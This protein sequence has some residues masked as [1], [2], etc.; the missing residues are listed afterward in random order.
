M[1]PVRGQRTWTAPRAPG[2]PCRRRSSGRRAAPGA[3][4]PPPSSSATVTPITSRSRGVRAAVPDAPW[5]VRSAP[6]A[7]WR[8]GG[9]RRGAA[10]DRRRAAGPD[11]PRHGIVPARPL[12]R[13]GRRDRGDDGAPRDRA[14]D[15][16]PLPAG[17]R[18]RA[19]DRRRRPRALRPSAPSSSSSPCGAPSSS[20]R[21]TSWR[22]PGGARRRGSPASSARGWPRRSSR[23]GSPTT[24]PP[25]STGVRGRAGPARRR[26][27]ALGRPL[28]ASSC[29]SST[30]AS[31][32][33]SARPTAPTCR[34]APRVLT[35]LGVEG[36]LARGRN[37]GHWRDLA[38]RSGRRW[39]PGWA[40]YPSRRGRPT[41]AGPSWSAVGCGPSG[42]APRPTSSGG[43][44]A[45]VGIVKQALADIGAE[46]VTLDGAETGWLLPD[47]LDEVTHDDRWV[48]LLPVLDP[49]VMG[50]KARDFY[51]DAAHVPPCSSTATATPAP[52]PGGTGGSS[53]AGCRTQP[54]SS[55][56]GTSRRCPRRARRALAVEAD[57]LTA[58]LDGVRVGTV[59]P[60]AAMKG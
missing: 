31:T 59:Y 17:P 33:P 37:G 36:L 41:R 54:G 19:D 53:A 43:S 4:A 47:D 49:T 22:R 16:L 35:Q 2:S 25:G 55:R 11:R 13:P 42:R 3:P 21:A 7:G 9:R 12:R 10:R 20:S 39:R 27:R 28:C 1:T 45:T 8:H 57:R 24:A 56:C 46:P 51:L 29:P 50:W 52:R 44:A 26:Q 6:P 5:G 30:A 38:A 18:R 23:A 48:A 40:T 14:G 15:R 32:S 60:S 34:I 58:W